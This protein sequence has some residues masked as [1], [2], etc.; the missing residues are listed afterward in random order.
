MKYSVL[1][2]NF[3]GYDL[4]RKPLETSPDATYV[5]V[6]DSP[7]APSPFIRKTDKK[8]KTPW[9]NTIKV[10]THP[11]DYTDT[12][13][14]IVM[15]SSIE[16]VHDITPMVEFCDKNGI[17]ALFIS[18]PY[19]ANWMAEI[20]QT[21]W[22]KRNPKVDVERKWL[23]ENFVDWRLNI[24]SMF[25][26]LKKTELTK[27]L[28]GEI[29]RRNE[30][31]AK[32]GSPPRPSQVIY[33]A[34]VANEFT[35]EVKSGK[36]SFMTSWQIRGGGSLMRIYNHGSSTPNIP[37]ECRKS[38]NIIGA[39]VKLHEFSEMD[40]VRTSAKENN[41]KKKENDWDDWED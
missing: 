5:F 20:E 17:E 41:D 19:N 14:V 26:I 21:L 3:G 27:R 8:E 7:R 35:D 2:Y 12:E 11:F 9:L 34:V 38:V 15:D 18:S 6:T 36:I 24:E 25:Y 28:F 10:K 30:E 16:I 31:L 29:N 22:K 23:R 37:L 33:S 40:V 4:P 1:T 32:L 39:D 13:W